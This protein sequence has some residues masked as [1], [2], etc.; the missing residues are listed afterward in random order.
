LYNEEDLSKHF[1]LLNQTKLSKNEIQQVWRA[2]KGL[3]KF[4]SKVSNS[5]LEIARR[6]GW[7]ENVMEIETRVRTAIAALEESGYLKR[8]QN[9]PRVFADSILSRNAQEAIDKINQS[10]RFDELQKVQAIRVIKKLFSSKSR[11]QS[12]EEVAESRIDYISD[13]LGIRKEDVINVVNLLREEK[14]LAD[15]R[16]LTAF[17]NKSKTLN[18]SLK[19][20]D[21]FNKIESFLLPFIEE[22]EQ[23]F[24]IK[25]LNEEAEQQGCSNVTTAKIKTIFNFWAIK[26]WIKRRSVAYSNNHFAIISLQ[27]KEALKEKLEKRHAV[28]QFIVEF[29]YKRINRHATPDQKEREEVLVEFSV[30]ELKDAFNNAIAS[31]GKKAS[32]EDVEESL[33]YLSRINA[34]KIEGGFLVVYNKLTIDRLEKDNR[35]QYTNKDYEKLNQF[36]ESKIQQIHIVGEYA[37]KMISDYKDALQFV[38]DYFQLNY[39]SFLRK[40]FP[41]SKIDDLKLKMTPRKF[42]QIFGELSARQLNIIKDNE[43]QYIVV[44]AGP[45]SGKTRVLVHKLAS[46]LLM[47]DVKHEQLLMV[48]FS[49]A[50]ATEFKK[51]LYK[52]IGNAAAFIEIKTFHS[53]C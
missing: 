4:R 1:T 25:E 38:E 34:I 51:R 40:Y 28:S 22:E 52:L 16:D 41:G 39:S 20:V 14:I 21:I 47:E 45:G 50:A 29:L 49:R 2:I 13:H 32:I 26:N 23:T 42:K 18:S 44:A 9:M 8:G 37:K 46:L 6:A 30:H 31:F 3:T 53:Y 17:I 33:F 24:Y 10:F 5:A 48:T 12:T 11:Q 35:K 19:V 43:A 7:D 15:T 36:Y 27:P